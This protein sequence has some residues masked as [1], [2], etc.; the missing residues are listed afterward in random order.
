M[1]Q[2]YILRAGQKVG[3]LDI[4]ALSSQGITGQSLVWTE[5][6]SDWVPAGSVE[7]LRPLFSTQT[8]HTPLTDSVEGFS[9]GSSPTASGNTGDNLVPR[10]MT[11]GV[12]PTPPK[13]YLLWSI[14]ATLFCC[15]PGGIVGIV[16]SSK[17]SPTYDRGDYERAEEYSRLA[18]KWVIISAIVGGAFI[19]IYFIFILIAALA[20]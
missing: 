18:R 3:P 2:Y 4:N 9:A 17:V 12:R 1:R 13:D 8:P 19:A 15:L 20:C 11:T 14:L 6:M 5:G 7:E 10:G 16:Y